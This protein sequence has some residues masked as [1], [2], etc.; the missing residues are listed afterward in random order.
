MRCSDYIPFILR[1]SRCPI[2]FI[3]I[4]LILQLG[5]TGM[6]YIVFVTLIVSFLFVNSHN[7]L[8]QTLHPSAINPQIQVKGRV[9]DR[10]GE[11][12]IGASVR[13]VGTS[14]GA[15]TDAQ[16]CFSFVASKGEAKQLVLTISF[17]GMKTQTL[18]YDGQKELV[19]VLKDDLRALEEVSIIANPNINAL[20]MRARSGVVATVDMKTLTQKP[21]IDFTLALQGS[22]PGLVVTNRGLLGEKPEI[23]IR[24]N[25]SF[26]K[27]DKANEPLYVL[28]GQII[29]SDAFM[30]INPMD[31]REIKVL[32]DA[33]ALALYG[34]KAANGVLEISSKRGMAGPLTISVSSNFGITTKGRQT[35]EMMDTSE[36]L[37]LERLMK[38][39]AA[40]GYFLSEDYTQSKHVT[41]A[42]IGR[43]Y[44]AVFGIS[45]SE[46]REYY[47]QYGQTELEQLKQINTN[48][49]DKLMHTNI[50]QSH[51][52]SLR[53]GVEQIRYYVSGN[54]ASQG[55]QLP[56]NETKRFTGRSSI[57]LHHD[58][59]LFSLSSNLGYAVTESPNNTKFSLQD[60][61]Y[62][63][64]PYEREDSPR[65]YS[66]PGL[67][68]RD[69]FD[70]VRRTS[71][72]KRFGTTLSMNLKPWK[73]WQLDGIIGF[74]FLLSES[75]HIIPGT[76]RDEMN[77]KRSIERGRLDQSRNTDFNYSANLRAT[78][79]KLF[80]EH[81]DLTISVNTDYYYNK[82]EVLG[83]VGH[84][85][86]N[87]LYINGVNHSLTGSYKPDFSGG[88]TTIAQAGFGIAAG[89]TYKSFVDLYASHKADASSILPADKRWNRAWALGMGLH[90]DHFWPTHVKELLSTTALKASWGSTASLGAVDVSLAIPV[91]NYSETQYYGSNYRLLSLKSMFNPSLKPEKVSDLN[92]GLSLGFVRNR[93]LLDLQ[94]YNRTTKEALLNVSI[95]SSNGFS[96]MLKNV[97]ELQNRGLELTLSAHI[98]QTEDWNMTTRVSVARSSN[99]VLKLYGGLK[100]IY[101]ST[102]NELP[103]YEVGHSYDNV[104]GFDF[105]GINPLSGYPK[106]LSATGEE[107]DFSDVGLKYEDF[108]ILGH[109]TPPYQGSFSINLGYK[110]LELDAQFYGVFGGIKPYGMSYVRKQDDAN[111]NAIKGQLERTWFARGDEGKLYPS[112]A[113]S[114]GVMNAYRSVPNNR[115]IARSDYLRLNMLS[116]RFRV[117]EQ[118]LKRLGNFA[119]YASISFQG[120]N[121]F[122]L[123]PYK[124]G[125]PESGVYDLSLQPV[126]TLNV[127][128]NF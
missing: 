35:T 65:L 100:R 60:M 115:M 85:L 77:S 5:C 2:R 10:S 125:S 11:P 110:N 71:T 66:Y 89:Y 37:E 128:L 120:S 16:G 43:R 68:F 108:K 22:V 1:I 80:A 28:D 44:A 82:R 116:L 97:G 45:P 99:K 32:K 88:K 26:R 81:H 102:E 83:V 13:V 103:D 86:G 12:L 34:V 30:T 79:Q 40:P 46:S 122:M 94:W 36:K 54:F 57:D 73:H 118:W 52:L 41:L 3:I 117:S 109:G 15:H 31:I 47:T 101:S 61:V 87:Q 93:F 76:N 75:L 24:G 4:Q 14:W 19:V 63:L 39:E 62:K 18:A 33:V 9:I 48:W 69:L 127:N 6:K 7:S 92:L 95:P 50:Y 58:I 20:D 49:F 91:F 70:Q 51:N 38:N 56:G 113:T 104:Y 84:G 27:G 78:Y 90:F 96:T 105:L 121:L 111:L 98:L 64:N 107:K 126:Y 72:E 21:M 25:S 8:G 17:M 59:G 124:G 114:S 112:P 119:N 123:T 53:G 67:T 55:G 74:D 29:S 42:D 23:R 106:Y